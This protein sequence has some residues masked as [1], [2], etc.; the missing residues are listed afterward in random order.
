M[1]V[2]PTRTGFADRCLSR[3]TITPCLVGVNTIPRFPEK[4]NLKT[5]KTRF[6]LTF[7]PDRD[8]RKT[9]KR[10]SSGVLPNEMCEITCSDHVTTAS[11]LPEHPRD[12]RMFWDPAWGLVPVQ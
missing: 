5:K 3:S 10:I 8:N 7:Y 12:C 6:F 4:A 9:K 2:E 11:P 1:G